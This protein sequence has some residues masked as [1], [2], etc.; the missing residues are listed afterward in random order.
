M[1]KQIGFIGIGLLAMFVIGTFS[2]SALAQDSSFTIIPMEDNF[3]NT[4]FV[5]EQL[6]V[7]LKT[8][9]PNFHAKAALNGGQELASINQINAHLIKIPINI[10]EK[11]I[12]AMSQNPN[13]LYVERNG[14]A[15]ALDVPDDSFYSHQWGT[16][17]IGMESV[18]SYPFDQGSGIK[19]AVI[20]EGVYYDHPDLVGI[21]ILKDIDKD[22]VNNDDDAYPSPNP[23]WFNGEREN[24]GTWVTGVIAAQTNN[25]MGIAGVGQF[26]I[27]PLRVLDECG[28]GNLFNISDAIIYAAEQDVHVINLSLGH[29]TFNHV[30][31]ENAVNFA[32]GDPDQIVVVA[33]S[34]NSAQEGNPIMY[35]AA[36]NKVIA[37][38]ATAPDDSITDYSSFGF[39]LDVSAPGGTQGGP[40]AANDPAATAIVTTGRA[41]NGFGY[42]CVTGT[43]FAAPL[44]AAVA[45]LV[46]SANPCATD[47]AIKS[48]L[49]F[50][51]DGYEDGWDPYFGYGIVNANNALITSLDPAFDCDPDTTPPVITVPDDVTLEAPADTTPANT[52]YATA[53]DAVD[54]S[55]TI[56][57]SD[58][59]SLDAQGIGTITRT[60]TATDDEGNS[61]SGDQVITVEDTT[62]PVI[63]V[64]DDVTLEAPADTTPANTG[65]ATA[66]DAVDPSPTISSSDVESLDAQGIG[67]ITRTWTATDDE[68]NS[69]SGDQVITVEDTTPVDL[70]TIHVGDLNWTASS[71][72][73]WNAVVYITVHNGESL[74]SGV[75]VDATF[76]DPNNASFSVNCT[77]VDGV[78][79]VNKTT[80][81]DYLI[82]TVD[83]LDS[84]YVSTITTHHDDDG[85]FDD[86]GIP[87]ATIMKGINSVGDSSDGGGD[88]TG[89]GG[90]WDC[91][92]KPHPKKCP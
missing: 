54:P 80:K 47:E 69:S 3:D 61:S 70:G 41:S 5:P 48:H 67:T 2:F 14:I 68:G 32:S 40:C 71:K 31:L 66:V 59:E 57:S 7:G 87:T 11:F 46:K 79:Q 73:N 9:D 72:K 4:K 30:T 10:E 36:F 20:D 74:V 88:S 78:C 17:R 35:P 50:T 52:G 55:P 42:H 38:G 27:L 13:V 29:D 56:S 51:S 22:Y 75:Q 39:Y 92:A 83:Y 24:H 43:S 62:P 64:P 8:S 53:V 60:W 44:V 63:T 19:I 84:T 82:F 23:C 15:K 16:K 34:G 12:Q 65:Y 58:V 33:A 45:G 85:D 18:W 37:V 21:N 77:T 86:P 76:T 6:I 49:E 25:A 28:S 81:L 91:T 89:G 1:N 90:S 26:D